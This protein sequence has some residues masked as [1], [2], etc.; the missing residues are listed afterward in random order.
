MDLL[1]SNNNKYTDM[2]INLTY[3]EELNFDETKDNAL[4]LKI[5]G[6]SCKAG[7]IA[8]K[9]FIIPNSELDNIVSTMKN[10][11]D[12]HGAY[13]LKDHGDTG[14]FGA[15]PT[16]DS[17][18]G[19]ITDAHKDGN[20]VM[21][22]GRIENADL[23]NKI[24]TKLV[25]ASSVGLKVNEMNCS[26]CGR[27]YGDHE[28]MHMLGKEYPEE[29]LQEMAKSFLD[30][31][32]AAIIGKNIEAREQSIVLFPAIKGASVGLNFSEESEKML[33]EVETEKVKHLKEKDDKCEECK[34]EEG[35]NAL[36]NEQV[37]E[38]LDKIVET[39][40]NAFKGNKGE[41]TMTDENIDKFTGEISTLKANALKLSED[42]KTMTGEK[43][44]LEIKVKNLSDENV[45]LKQV[46][47]KYKK[48]EEL[49]LKAEV[50]ALVVKLSELRKEKE[51]P[52]KDYKVTSLEVL[53]AEFELLNSLPRASAKGEVAGETE[54]DKSAKLKEDIR[55]VIFKKRADK[56]PIANMRKW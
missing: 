40:N 49:R 27:K 24:R 31:P 50:D 43:S 4:P 33:S 39:F 1:K 14:M 16:V 23:A 51:L 20:S 54:V 46:V 10:G 56:Q 37:V 29:G 36:T 34:V 42:L 47:D 17:L 13:I 8:N 48:E 12:G 11:V 25:T 19:R 52:M 30:K 7:Y 53:N 45:T 35:K 21:Y 9:H 38:K 44:G 6:M 55:E 28:C 32:I 26:I 3:S 22:E 2:N 18:V 5:K 41:Q 15:G